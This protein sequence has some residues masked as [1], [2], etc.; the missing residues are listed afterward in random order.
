MADPTT[1]FFEELGRRGH[2]PLLEKATGNVRFDLSDGKKT[3]RWLVAVTRG[4]LAV[5]RRH[6]RADCVVSADRALFDGVAS[7][8]TNAMAALLR[9]AMAVEG[10]VRLLVAFQRLFPGAAGPQETP[11]AGYARRLR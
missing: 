2:E 11:P 3:D 9:G 10:D 7:G 1:E 6:V 8:K 4:D 5:S